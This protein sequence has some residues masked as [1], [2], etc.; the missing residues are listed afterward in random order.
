MDYDILHLCSQSKENFQK[1]RRYVKPH[2]VVKET[3]II[4]D[5]MDKYYK[6]FPGVTEFNW[7]AFSAYLIADQS[8]RLTDDSI[9]KLRM[10]LT[11]A[12][13][14]TPH[15]AHEEVIKTIIELDY[16]S[17]IM[18]ECE[19]VKEGS[20]DLEHVHILATDALKS[21][22]RYI[23][24]DELFVSAD[25]SSIADRISS[26]GYEWRLDVL[27]RSLGPLRTG[28][29]VIVA[30]RVEVG[31]TTFLASEVSHIAQQLPKGRPV[32]WV[33]NEEESSVVFF[34]IVQAAL[35]KESKDI[36]AD[37][38]VAMESY[39]TLMGGDKNKIRVTKDTNHVR[40]LETL[41]R[42]VNPGL[43]VFDQ[44]DKVDGFNKGD[45]RED[46]KL[47]KIYKWARELA[48]TYGPVIAASQ[49]SA[50]VVD[51]K[52]PPFIG[53]DALRG[54]K[55]DKPGEADVV[56]TIGKYKEPKSPEEEM[57]RTINVPKNK[58]P[59]GGSKHVE[60]ER[61]GQY[62]VTIDPVRARFE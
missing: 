47:G 29:F 62:L 38:K 48:R 25:L 40:D 46:I 12:K 18:E 6:T 37:S 58:L 28:N 35:G 2:I 39:S 3:N 14:F 5:G 56:L 13:M 16:L 34:R 26:S 42:E 41:F 33:N 31:K 20:S 22:E 4:L 7:D 24:K 55:T 30:A 52:D 44:L 17:Q 50:S 1:Y 15:H 19:R 32:V 23:E 57:I 36:I 9:V 53:M 21:V 11:K 10:T 43:I 60:T 27:N 59:G 45:D 51:L 61:H 8:K 49:L 54:S